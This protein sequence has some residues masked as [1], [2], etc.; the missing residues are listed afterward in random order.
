MSSSEDFISLC[1]TE[2]TI[3]GRKYHIL[4][5]GEKPYDSDKWMQMKLNEYRTDTIRKKRE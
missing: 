2:S 5:E 1:A 4:C 3:S